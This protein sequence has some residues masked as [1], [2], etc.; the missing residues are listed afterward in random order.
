MSQRIPGTHLDDVR[1]NPV[2]AT[3]RREARRKRRE[4][5][6]LVLI[7]PLPWLVGGYYVASLR[8]MPD[9]V[10]LFSGI[11]FTLTM[12]LL[13]AC[14]F[15]FGG[16]EGYEASIALKPYSLDLWMSGVKADELA[17][18]I[19]AHAS[20]RYN[21]RILIILGIGASLLLSLG[22]LAF[23]PRVETTTIWFAAQG[24][25]PA[26][27]F[28]VCIGRQDAFLISNALMWIGH[29]R[30]NYENE[31]KELAI[32]GENRS[33]RLARSARTIILACLLVVFTAF[34]SMKAFNFMDR[35]ILPRFRPIPYSDLIAYGC[36]AALIHIA[37]GMAAGL[38]IRV[39]ATSKA[40]ERFKLLGEEMLLLTQYRAELKKDK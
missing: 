37:A 23:L 19:V 7:Y 9:W 36:A 31:F 25:V 15:F 20:G 22:L 14:L 10:C 8:N 28:L 32:K 12:L 5:L 33:H 39:R 4:R 27:V 26:T 11:H 30:R 34:L 21:L 17:T 2:F 1:D 35:L 6:L 38:A 29:V 16:I 18:A 24:F 40:T 3:L 13:L